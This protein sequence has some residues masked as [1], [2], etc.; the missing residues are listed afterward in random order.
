MA[1]FLWG[2]VGSGRKRA[3][4]RGQRTEE[5]GKR[6]EERGKRK[7]E[8][9]KRTKEGDEPILRPGRLSGPFPL[10]LIFCLF[11]L[12][13]FLCICPYSHPPCAQLI[14]KPG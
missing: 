10:G 1:F 5:R 6:K 2:G 14:G 3:E 8:R 11:P 13:S 7:E 12:P 4:D 9:G